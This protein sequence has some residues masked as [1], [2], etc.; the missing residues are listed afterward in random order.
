MHNCGSGH[1]A[2]LFTI[3]IWGT[4]FIA[5]KILLTA[6]TP[7]EILFLRFALGLAALWLARPQRLRT[8][9]YKQ[10]LTLAAAGLCGI[11]LYYLLENIAL[12]YT[13]ASNVGVIISAAP[14]LTALLECAA[15]KSCRA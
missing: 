15:A 10:E 13:L 4:T 5:T 3:L 12:T 1:L 2:A 6:L 8:Q 11:C 14:F 9:N 7:V